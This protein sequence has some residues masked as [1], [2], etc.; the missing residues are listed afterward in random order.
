MFEFLSVFRIDQIIEGLQGIV[1]PYHLSLMVVG[2]ILASLVAAAP[3]I[4]SLLLLS[5]LLPFATTLE[6]FG[7]IALIFGVATVGNTANTFS[8]VLVGV[9]G[10][11]GSQATILD[12]FPMAKNGE[13]NRAFGAAFMA[14]LVGA[15]IGATTFMITLPFFSPLVLSIGSPEFLMLVLWGLSA[16]AVLGGSQP[17]KGLIGAVFGLSVALI[18]TDARTGIE[19][20][21]FGSAY[22]WDGVSLVI[23]AMG[24]FAV[25]EM[26]NLARRK[27]SISDTRHSA[28][29]FGKGSPMS[30]NIG[31]WLRV[32]AWSAFGSVRYRGWA[33]PWR[34]GSPMPMRCRRKKTPK[35]LA[36]AMS[37]V[38]LRP[39]ALTMP[40]R[41]A[42]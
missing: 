15:I 9:P 8:S 34:T 39:K 13:A 23:V 4:G 32:A 10:G 28:A 14:S 40:R 37:A 36:R 30:T 31:G 12:G 35:I 21:T 2:V 19:R 42:I 11:S 25:P 17:V 27:T 1:T 22:L 29:D 18:G 16:V 5:L 41:A 24:I 26:V 6:P 7:F 38:C 3:G 33:A 20:F